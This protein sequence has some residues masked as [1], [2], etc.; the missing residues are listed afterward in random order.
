MVKKK[1]KEVSLTRPQRAPPGM[2]LTEEQNMLQSMFGGSPTIWG[3][4]QDSLPRFH[5]TLT[6]GNGLINSGDDEQET[7]SIFGMR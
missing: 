1:L 7:A 3:Q 4:E 5:Q 6:S 2:F